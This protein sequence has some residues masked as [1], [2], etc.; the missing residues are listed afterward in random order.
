MAR[1]IAL[2][3]EGDEAARVC[4]AAVRQVSVTYRDTVQNIRIISSEGFMAA[5]ER[6]Y[7]TAMVQVI[8][9]R[10]GMIQTGYDAEG[11]LV[12]FELFDGVSYRDLARRSAGRAL[13]MLDAP[14]AP[15]GR[16]PVVISS[17]AGGTMIHEAIGHGLEA[18][19]A[20]RGLSV[21]SGKRGR[22]IASPVVTVIDDGTLPGKRGSVAVDDEGTPSHRTVLVSEGVL[23][24]YLHDRRTALLDKV[25]P[26]GNGRRE[27][28]EHKP[29]PR[30][31]NT[32]IAP[33]TV[34]PAEVIA[35]VNKGLFVMKMGGG[36]VNTVTGDFVF[37]VQ[38]G[39]LIESGRVGDM[40]RGATLVGNGPEILKSIDLVGS[41]LGFS[42]GTCGKDS[43][44]VPVSD[45]MP[46]LRIREL[47]VGGEVKKK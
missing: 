5:D 46:T 45:A 27:S 20:Q 38:E 32:F 2:V 31:T 15:G 44:G 16:M 19:L 8:A 9:A 30:M 4:G 18:D 22:V 33:G 26:T 42:I 6:V 10:N 47:V 28:F 13:R 29:I 25:Q 43:Q 24:S 12:G 37:D 7:T 23:E 34:A 41:D 3:R 35:S 36:Q 40:V 21:Y 14:R 1:K 39:Y 11:G 17:A